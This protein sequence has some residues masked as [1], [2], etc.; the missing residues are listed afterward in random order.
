DRFAKKLQVGGVFHFASVWLPYAEEVWVL[1]ENDSIYRN[2][3]S[4]FAPRPEWRRLT[5][6]EKRGQFIDHP[7][8]DI[9]FEKI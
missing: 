3:Y 7:I 4:G 6:F 5:K 9:L 8:S 2:L 1:L